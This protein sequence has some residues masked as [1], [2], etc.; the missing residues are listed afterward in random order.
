MAKSK[1]ATEPVA[2]ADASEQLG[3]GK[4]PKGNR[5]GWARRQLLRGCLLSRHGWRLDAAPRRLHVH[6][7]TKDETAVLSMKFE[8]TSEIG[9]F[10]RLTWADIDGNDWYVV[11]QLE[12][13]K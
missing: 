2:G 4:L 1:K 9:Q 13:A 3:E 5:I 8:G 10:T 11:D 12:L 6:L 7:A